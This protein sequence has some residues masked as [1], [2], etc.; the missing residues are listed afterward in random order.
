MTID[1]DVTAGIFDELDIT[2]SPSN[3]GVPTFSEPD[4]PS[5]IAIASPYFSFDSSF[6]PTGA[7]AAS[8]LSSIDQSILD[9]QVSSGDV[10]A[11]YL[12]SAASPLTAYGGNVNVDAGT[13]N[14]FGTITANGAPTIKIKNNSPDYL[15]LGPISIPPVAAGKVVYTGTA[16]AFP[17]T[18]SQS[19]RAS[20]REYPA[21][22]RPVGGRRYE[23][24]TGRVPGRRSGQPARAGHDL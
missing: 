17:G 1:G 2:I 15:I 16:T 14:G 13:I 7:I 8:G 20:G 19:R 5:S 11:M 4:A 24:R 9:N 22:V 10:A 6:S 18:V 12:G 23:R 3:P 21:D